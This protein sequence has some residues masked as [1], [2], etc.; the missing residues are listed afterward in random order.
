MSARLN[1]PLYPLERVPQAKGV[2]QNSP[3]KG[4][5][6]TL[7]RDGRV[8][9]ERQTDQRIEG[10][11]DEPLFERILST[12]KGGI[13]N[14]DSVSSHRRKRAT[15]IL[16]FFVARLG[17]TFPSCELHSRFGSAFRTRV[18]ELNR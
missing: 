7:P 9:S 3:A 8:V 10:P 4:G 18:S 2:E 13:P 5:N 11:G 15:Q 16:E 1:T 14:M 12:Q 17:K 6:R